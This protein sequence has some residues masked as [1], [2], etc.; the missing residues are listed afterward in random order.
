MEEKSLKTFVCTK[1]VNTSLTY[2]IS[3][4]VTHQLK[5]MKNDVK[6]SY[7][8]FHFDANKK[9]ILCKKDQTIKKNN[10]I[11]TPKL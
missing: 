7:F 1:V 2:L 4:F 11:E 9:Y 5:R 10:Q 8:S 6:K 3:I